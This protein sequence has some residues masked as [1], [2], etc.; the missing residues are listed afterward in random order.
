M[1]NYNATILEMLHD[2]KTP[3]SIYKDSLRILAEEQATK[4]QHEELKA[5]TSKAL[6]EAIINYINTWYPTRKPED[7]DGY[8]DY[9]FETLEENL[10]SE[11]ESTKTSH[12]FVVTGKM[13]N[14]PPKLVKDAPHRKSIA[15]EDNGTFLDMLRQV[16]GDD[17]IKLDRR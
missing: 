16:F 8:T 14:E 1:D 7:I 9:M 4:A 15:M 17:E 3:E 5:K 12:P 10:P 2:G 13:M 11:G 6:R